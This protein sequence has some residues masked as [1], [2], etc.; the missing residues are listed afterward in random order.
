MFSRRRMRAWSSPAGNAPGKCWTTCA[1]VFRP[2]ASIAILSGGLHRYTARWR[3][4]HLHMVSLHMAPWK[5][6]PYS[7][8]S[9]YGSGTERPNWHDLAPDLKRDLFRFSCKWRG[10][11]L[12]KPVEG[13]D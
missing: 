11:S 3:R 13:T 10:R 5:T 6:G 9:W 12:I 8:A 7:M 4:H 2:E 1:R